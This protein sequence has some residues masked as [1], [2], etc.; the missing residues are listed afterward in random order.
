MKN[1][2]ELK[3]IFKRISDLE[4]ISAITFWDA[5]CMM[6]SGG[7]DARAEAMAT[8]KALQHSM[9][10][11]PKIDE[12]IDKA[13]SEL[14]E[15]DWDT[16][17]LQ[18]MQRLYFNATCLPQNLVEA[19]AKASMQSEQ[20]WRILRKDNNW[21]EF[22]PLLE[23]TFSLVKKAAVIHAE[24]RNMSTYDVLL[25]EY[26]PDITQTLIDPI[27]NKLKDFL[28]NFLDKVLE[29]Q[30]SIKLFDIQGSYPISK[31]KALGLTL[32]QTIGFDF[33]HGRLDISHHPF[34]GGV[35]QDVRVTTRYNE[36][37]FITSAMAICHETGHAMYEQG[38]PIKWIDQPVGAPLGMSIHESQS[39]LVEMQACRSREFMDFLSQHVMATFGT[40]KEFTSEN[41]YNLYTHVKRDYI[42]VDAD[43]VTYPLHIIL[44]YEIEK[45]LFNDEIEIK[46]LPEIWDQKMQQYLGLSTKNNYKDGV[47]QDVHWPSGIFGYFPAY[48]LGALVA[49]QLF[50]KAKKSHPNI[51]TNLVHGDF[52]VLINWLREKIHKN[53]SKLTF[54][55]LIQ[56]ATGE[57]LNPDYFIK[58]LEERYI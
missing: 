35:P 29:A 18:K 31:Q 25:D 52:T 4:H 33:N 58:H 20:A 5:A 36:N 11:D 30:T 15:D 23:N 14:L 53:A 17:N 38:L 28:P 24:K 42:R 55:S 8:L 9:L 32:M 47:M 44:R 16:A 26:S 48:S 34:C 27:F 22:L 2:N 40:Q 45:A 39:L 46:D 57:E 13:T 3:N 21:H 43:E 10:T 12:L 50:N 6:P 49:A 51:L 41:L 19:K 1:Y 7:G 54:H 56:N 37:E